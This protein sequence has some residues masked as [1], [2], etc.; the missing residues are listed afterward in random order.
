[1]FALTKRTNAEVN[2]LRGIGAPF[3]VMDSG[4]V[5]N[6]LRVKIHNHS[7]KDHAYQ[8]TL[9]NASDLQLVVPNNPI[10]VKAGEL[11]TEGMF[12]IGKAAA[13][14]RGRDL[15]LV[16]DDGETLKK[17]LTFRLLGP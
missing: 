13:I 3:V 4:D 6:T 16:V 14:G 5:Q 17:T 15:E 1:M 10:P 11:R 2:V 8:V 12:V 7:G 9:N